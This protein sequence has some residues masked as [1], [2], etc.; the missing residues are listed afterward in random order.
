MNKIQPQFDVRHTMK[1]RPL[2]R[3]IL[4]HHNLGETL[5]FIA[6][7]G[8]CALVW[9]RFVAP[10]RWRFTQLD[11]PL[12]NLGAEFN[13][14]RLLQLADLHTGRV[15]QSYLKQVIKQSV[16]AKPDLIVITGDLI[17]Y[18][19]A[20]LEKLDELLQLLHAPDGVVAI[21]G[22]HDYREYSWRHVGPR[23]RHR[24]IHKRL[25]VLLERRNVKLLCNQN[26]TLRRG[27]SRL[28]LVGL[29]ELWA[30]LA[31]PEAA[32]AGVDADEA[33]IC[34]VHNPD[35][36]SLFRDFPWQWMLC[37]HTHGG[38]VN[39]PLLG[40]M[41]V[42]VENRR[43]MRGLFEFP[44]AKPGMRRLYVSSGVGHGTPVRFRVAP[45]AVL[46]TLRMEEQ[47]T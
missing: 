20:A 2:E 47:K 1:G 44:D 45:E 29:D 30:G 35:G 17:D 7:L 15:R 14:C 22:N 23:S 40:S 42:P 39:L 46:F 11:M 43:F 26:M 6:V 9:P 19:P 5:K 32:F 24:S 38:Q 16:A 34:L 8:A 10:Y 4:L 12:K 36:F 27:T 18:S 21:F 28:R 33:C 41:F 13:G 3:L 31:D 37:G 25:R